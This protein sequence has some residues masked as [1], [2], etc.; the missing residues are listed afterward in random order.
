MTERTIEL[1]LTNS[2]YKK[3][4]SNQPFQVTYQQLNGNRPADHHVEIHLEKKDL[5]KLQRNMRNKKGFRFSP[6]NVL[7][8]GLLSSALSIGK[9]ALQNKTLRKHYKRD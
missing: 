5:T 1:Y 4:D 9:Q 3:M 8:S 7:A 2:Q 6:K